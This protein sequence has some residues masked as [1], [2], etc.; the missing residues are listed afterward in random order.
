M[1]PAVMEAGNYSLGLVADSVVSGF[2][3]VITENITQILT[4]MG[5]MLGVAWVV[6]K[7]GAAKKGR[8]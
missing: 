7:F 1:L 8:I 3:G 4:L 6:R 2:F 5:I